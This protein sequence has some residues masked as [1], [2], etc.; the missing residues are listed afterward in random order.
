M[1]EN[2][3]TPGSMSFKGNIASNWRLWKQK[4]ELFMLASGKSNKTDEVKVAI[5]LNFLGDERIGR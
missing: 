1:S 5:L 2:A 3:V 4:F